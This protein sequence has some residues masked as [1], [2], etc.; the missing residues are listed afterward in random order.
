MRR[1][2]G[3]V[4]SRRSKAALRIIAGDVFVGTTLASMGCVVASLR[5]PCYAQMCCAEPA[6]LPPPVGLPPQR[7]R[8]SHEC[9]AHECSP[10]GGQAIRA[11][12]IRATT[13]GARRSMQR[14][15]AARAPDPLGYQYCER[16]RRARLAGVLAG[17]GPDAIDA[18]RRQERQAR[19]YSSRVE[20]QLDVHEPIY[21]GRH[22]RHAAP[23]REGRPGND[24]DRATAAPALL[25][26]RVR[27]L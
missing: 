16:S 14:W 15:P 10:L 7:G 2:L 23:R 12:A 24:V 13:F 9:P 5:P 11:G 19:S 27:L 26:V 4:A 18:T 20:R 17:V 25:V 3:G 1:G 21:I 8:G 6:R 22:R